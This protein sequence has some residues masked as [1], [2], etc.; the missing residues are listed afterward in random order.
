MNRY[1]GDSDEELIIRIRDGEREI[2]DY[3]IGKYKPLVLK[4]VKS[5]YILGG[6]NDDLIQ[7]GMIGLYKAIRDYDA[8]RD[9][10]FMTFADICVSRQLLTAIQAS[11]RK[12]H[13]PLNT[14]VSIYSGQKKEN[15]END[16]EDIN[17]VNVLSLVTEKSPE[18]LLMNRELIN[19]VDNIME[20]KLSVLE[21]DA[22]GLHLTGLST[23]EIA[24]VL[25]RDEKSTDNALTR[26]KQKLRKGLGA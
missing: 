3:I 22:F 23:A 12:K 8:G 18:E 13:I 10:S 24:R 25:S 16:S 11:S 7:E 17:L 4:K 2:S 21:R 14:Y 5:M 9:A 1:D 15:G 6:D 20:T 19:E 26:A